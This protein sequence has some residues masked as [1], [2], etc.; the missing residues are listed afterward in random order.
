MRLGDRPTTRTSDARS[1]NHSDA[2]SIRIDLGEIPPLETKESFMRGM[3][4][5]YP[6]NLN[7]KKTFKEKTSR[8]NGKV[9]NLQSYYT[10]TQ[11]VSKYTIQF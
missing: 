8:A 1:V 5:L 7:R 10:T 11:E 4:P 3:E 9:S 2:F 6:R